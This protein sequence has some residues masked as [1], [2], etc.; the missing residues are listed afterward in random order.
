M[1]PKG[2]FT[3]RIK[4]HPLDQ[5]S[6]LDQFRSKLL[7]WGK[8]NFQSFPWRLTHDPYAILIAEI[9]L[10]RTHVNQVVPIYIEFLQKYPGI[11]YIHDAPEKEIWEALAGLGLH[12]RI[13]LIKKMADQIL[14]RFGSIIPQEKSLL[15]SLPGINDYI[16]SA[17]RCF[18]WNY[19][20]PV[21]DTNTVR[22]AGRIFGLET[23]DSSRRNQRVRL[24]ISRLIDPNNPADFNYALL[25]LAHLVC[26]RRHEPE[27]A[28]CPVRPYCVYA[29]SMNT[30]I[31]K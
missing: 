16:A 22:I 14:T 9:M 27:C 23:K 28:T 24:L 11:V 25:D 10:H 7:T 26:H 30:N 6:I 12:W 19:P 5:E 31:E 13:A 4:P 15:M 2:D 20:D 18:A 17:V 8:L 21:I 1:M 29:R 3:E